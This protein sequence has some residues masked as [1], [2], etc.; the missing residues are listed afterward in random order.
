MKMNQENQILDKKDSNNN[1]QIDNLNNI[2]EGVSMRIRNCNRGWL[3]SPGICEVCGLRPA[4]V[5][6]DLNFGSHRECRS[7]WDD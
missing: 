1:E 4:T 2:I 7:C 6:L 5:N 3:R